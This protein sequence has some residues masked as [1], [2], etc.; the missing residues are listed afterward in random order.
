M[1][2]QIITKLVQFLFLSVLVPAAIS[3]FLIVAVTLTASIGVGF[4]VL[5]HRLVS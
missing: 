4:L 3:L 5:F 1:A 2:S